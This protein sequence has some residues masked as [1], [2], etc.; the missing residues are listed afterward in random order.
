MSQTCTVRGCDRPTQTNL[1]PACLTETVTSIRELAYS[2]SDGHRR[3]G[4][5]QDLQDTAVRRDH[6]GAGGV[7]IVA[8]AAEQPVPFHEDASTLLVQVRYDVTRWARNVAATY[9][10]LTLTATTVPE[11]AEWMGTFPNLLAEHPYASTLHAEM[12]STARQIRRMIDRAPDKVYLGQCGYEERQ[13]VCLQ[14]LYAL[15][16]SP[17]VRCPTC[18]SDW[19]TQA[20]RDH[21]L[22]VVENQLETATEIS[23]ALSRLARPVSAAAIRGYAHRGKLTPHPPRHDDPRQDPL[24]RIGDV[25][26][27]LHNTQKEAS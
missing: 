12:L 21:L 7:G 20:R 15:P 19:D 17:Y 8:R 1:C 18:G 11:A 9:P 5:V 24:Y 23:R 16:H 4:L 6:T 26:D 22:T 3:P 27:L 10:H 2:Y 13:Q 25:L 14:D